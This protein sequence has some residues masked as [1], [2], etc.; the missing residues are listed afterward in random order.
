MRALVALSILAAGFAGS[1]WAQTIGAPGNVKLNEI[2]ESRGRPGCPVQLS[3]EGQIT[4]ETARS[5]TSLIELA[6]GSGR[7][8]VRNF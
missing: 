2:C 4:A 8:N 7:A 1:A 6:R 5:F 3:I